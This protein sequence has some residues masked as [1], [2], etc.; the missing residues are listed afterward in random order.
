[1][2]NRPICHKNIIAVL[3]WRKIFGIYDIWPFWPG[4]FPWKSFSELSVEV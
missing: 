3:L 4:N 2:P 1:M